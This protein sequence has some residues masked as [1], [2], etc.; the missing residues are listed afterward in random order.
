MDLLRRQRDL[1][2]RELELLRS[3]NAFLFTDTLSPTIVFSAVILQFHKCMD[4]RRWLQD[5][6]SCNLKND[7]LS[8][9][10]GSQLFFRKDL[11]VLFCSCGMQNSLFLYMYF[12]FNHIHIDMRF[13]ASFVF[14]RFFNFWQ[15]THNFHALDNVFISF[16]YYYLCLTLLLLVCAKLFNTRL[17]ILIRAWRRPKRLSHFFRILQKFLCILIY[18]FF[19]ISLC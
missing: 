19:F 14:W 5:L 7:S 6:F 3:E 4:L 11:S 16:H 2:Q 17:M 8:F 1:M 12:C 9:I 18:C 10:F 15:L 13:P